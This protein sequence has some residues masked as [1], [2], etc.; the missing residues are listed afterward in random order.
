MDS[1]KPNKPSPFEKRTKNRLAAPDRREEIRFEPLT[2]NRR[3][4]SGR[5][6][7]DRDVWKPIEK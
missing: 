4:N 6:L 1:K 3:Q 2:D 7:T 5:R